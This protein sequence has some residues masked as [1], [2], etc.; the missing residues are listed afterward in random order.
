MQA[1]KASS[2]TKPGWAKTFKNKG[3]LTRLLRLPKIISHLLRLSHLGSKSPPKRE[4][5]LERRCLT[6]SSNFTISVS[7]RTNFT[8]F[9]MMITGPHNFKMQGSACSRS[10]LIAESSRLRYLGTLCIT[11][12]P[13]QRFGSL[14][15]GASYHE[16]ATS[17]PAAASVLAAGQDTMSS[18]GTYSDRARVLAEHRP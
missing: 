8:I 3:I 17:L 4:T 5:T 14:S 18:G 13:N 16:P 11:L 7:D 1:T 6:I 9:L 2:P 15:T 10:S 12:P